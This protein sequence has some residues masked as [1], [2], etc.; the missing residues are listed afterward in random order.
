MEGL[1]FI[2]SEGDIRF[3][4]EKLWALQFEEMKFWLVGKTEANYRAY[5][6]FK[7]KKAKIPKY[8]KLLSSA[9]KQ[10]TVN[11]TFIGQA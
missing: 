8:K 7:M 3:D 10:A 2:D 5:M 6:P 4:F 11:A 9:L 1:A